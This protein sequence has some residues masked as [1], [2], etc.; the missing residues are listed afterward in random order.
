MILET[1][2]K[3]TDFHFGNLNQQYPN[4]K[5]RLINYKKHQLNADPDIE[6]NRFRLSVMIK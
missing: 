3:T 2:A 4:N 5:R 1:C 6:M